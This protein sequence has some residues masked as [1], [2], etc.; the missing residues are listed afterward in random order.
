M[1]NKNNLNLIIV[2][3]IL[4]VIGC[5]CPPPK[6]GNNTGAPS[7]P[8]PTQPQNPANITTNAPANVNKPFNYEKDGLQ[9]VSSKWQKGGFGTVAIWKVTIK[10]VSDKP[11]GDIK[12][13]TEYYSETKNIVSKG[14]TKGLLG[15]DTI[16]KIVPP[17]S[18]RTFEVNDGFV[19]DEAESADFQLE[20]WR[21][22]EK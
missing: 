20:S 6:T 9:H 12:F 15:K 8:S 19:G 3:G 18:T 11:L 5:A 13:S 1:K 21:I 22:I 2:V 16:E 7:S 14:G 10:N 17:K 4:L